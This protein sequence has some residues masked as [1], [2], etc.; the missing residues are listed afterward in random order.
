MTI[1]YNDYDTSNNK[2]ANV[3]DKAMCDSC[4]TEFEYAEE[5]IQ[6]EIADTT[7]FLCRSCA[8]ELAK[9]II[10]TLI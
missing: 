1:D 9:E 6:I 4:N 3:D 7:L 2:C 10:D 8:S 5:C